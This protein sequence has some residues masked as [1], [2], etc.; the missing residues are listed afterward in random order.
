[1]ATK[2]KTVHVNLTPQIANLLDSEDSATQLDA[3]FAR[4][5]AIAEIA[6]P[7]EDTI[8]AEVRAHR[9]G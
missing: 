6:A 8:C 5:D 4:M 3:V 2:L 9:K 1:M 7:H